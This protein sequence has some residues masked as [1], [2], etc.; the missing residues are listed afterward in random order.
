[1][2]KQAYEAPRITV[3]FFAAEKLLTSSS[4]SVQEIKAM[5]SEKAGT[6]NISSLEIIAWNK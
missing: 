3:S 6:A 5:M 2:K 1:M 4:R